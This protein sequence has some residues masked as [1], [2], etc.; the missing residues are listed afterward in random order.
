MVNRLSEENIIQNLQDAG[1]DSTVI[2]KF[3][4][5]LENESLEKQLLFLKCQRCGLL[6]DLHKAQKKIDCLDYLIYM[7]KKSS[8]VQAST[9]DILSEE[10]EY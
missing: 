10:N 6:E 1:C 9:L 8:S 2:K 7:L 5:C 4:E 3:I